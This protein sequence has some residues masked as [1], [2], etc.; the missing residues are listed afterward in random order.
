MKKYFLS[1]VALAAMLFATS[2]Q[3]SLVEPQIEGTTTFTV[4]LPDQMGTKAIIGDASN[5]TELLVDVYAQNGTA[6]IYQT[7]GTPNGNGNGFDVKLNLIQD[8]AYDILFWAQTGNGYV[9]VATN[10]EVHSFE[11]LR[12]V[13]MNSNFLNN[14]NGAAFFHAEKGFVPN[15]TSKNITLVRPFAQLNL[16]TTVASLQPMTGIVALKSSLIT[17]KGVATHFNVYDGAGYGNQD[18]EYVYGPETTGE[19]A[20]VAVPKEP[21]K[22]TIGTEPNVQTFNYVS[23]NY[24][25]VLGD[26]KAV[27]DVDAVIVVEDANGTKEIEHSF[28][29]V[30][31]QENYR[32]NIVGNLI[33]STTDFIVTVDNA[34]AKEDN[35]SLLP[36]N[37]YYV[38]DN[39]AA[40]NTALTNGESYVAINMIE[41]NAP[42]ININAND[43]ETLYLQLPDTDA[44]VTVSGDK[45]KT[46][47]ISVPNVDPTNRGLNIT[48]NT[49]NSHVEISGQINSMPGVSTSNTTLVLNGAIVTETIVI[50]QGNVVV[51][52]G[53]EILGKIKSNEAV[54]IFNSTDEEIA[55]EGENIVVV[56]GTQDEINVSSLAELYAAVDVIAAGGVVNIDNNIEGVDEVVCLKKNITINGNGKLISGSASRI[57]RIVNP[58]L[59]V[60]M[61]D[62]NIVSKAVRVGTNDIRGISLDAD[63]QNVSL[64]LNNCSVDFTHESANNWAYAVNISGGTAEKHNLVINGG[65]Y[66]GANVVNVWGKEHKISI[67]GAELTSNYPYNEVYYGQCI[68]FEGSANTITVKNTKFKGDHAVAIEEAPNCVENNIILENNEDNTRYAVVKTGENY[69]YSL[70]EAVASIESEGE[71]KILR[72]LEIDNTITIGNDKN[73][74]LNLN[75]KTITGVDELSGDYSLIDN[76]GTLTIH[77]PGKMT[78]SISEGNNKDGYSAVIANNPGGELYIAE[79]VVIEHLG[80]TDNSYDIYAPKPV[81]MVGNTEYYSINEAIAAWTN[82]STLTLLADV[83]LSDVVTLK[84]TE[85][86]T[87]NLGIY[88]MTAASGKHA[89]EITCNGRSSASYAL[90]INADATNPGGITATGQSCIYYEKNDSTKDRPIILINNGVFTGSYS[91]NSTSN[92]NTN[93]PQVWINGGVFNSYM[94]LTK[95]MLRISGGTFH[96]AINCT[97]D[98]SAYREIKGGRFKSW[99]FMTADAP[100]KFWVGSGNGNYDV[101]CY[102]DDEGYLV[103]GGPVITEFGDKF[104]AKATNYSKWSSYLK[105]SSVAEYGLYYTNAELAIKKHGEANVEFPSED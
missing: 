2:C 13:P 38:V 85:H 79:D 4:Q 29:N 36:D 102:V 43:I 95:N 21:S 75:G 93:C 81:A 91:I 66:E 50:N 25:A 72:N 31:V 51:G 6:P 70:A 100:N 27:V 64:T 30:P 58:S 76:S 37:D 60:K 18:V 24:L 59:M 94:N 35:G 56:E 40:A 97:G 16:G 67:D 82:G 15:G 105:Y 33:S 23:M 49:P 77:G 41:K 71:I 62:L 54:V 10:G 53:S 57:F 3:E 68:R 52:E 74:T 84:S 98:S 78:L 104:A 28:T 90:T 20:P 1:L 32:T 80:E 61:N 22:L 103:V 39:V 55:V 83:T 47:Y 45:V 92:G 101:G 46:I 12:S 9:S 99:Q 63:L 65:K 11:S 96:A 44:D 73:I 26:A 8:Q 17:V 88:T 5:V 86:H 34:F 14:D 19:K 48:I 7:K 69:F 89:I 42:A 87:L